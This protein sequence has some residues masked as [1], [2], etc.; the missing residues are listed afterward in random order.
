MSE[1][2]INDELRSLRRQ[3]A[4]LQ[5]KTVGIPVR[6]AKVRSGVTNISQLKF[7]ILTTIAASDWDYATARLTQKDFKARLFTPHKESDEFTGDFEPKPSGDGAIYLKGVSYF[8]DAVTINEGNF[9]VG[10]GIR[11]SGSPWNKEPFYVE[12]DFDENDWETFQVSVE[13]FNASCT[14]LPLEEEE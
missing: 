5:M 12:D 8:P 4:D 9:R 7:Q 1:T 14:Q 2:R 11:V 3:V 10:L 13:L 6:I